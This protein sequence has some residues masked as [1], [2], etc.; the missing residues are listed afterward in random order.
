MN[1][2]RDLTIVFTVTED[3]TVDGLL[4]AFDLNDTWPDFLIGVRM[5]HEGSPGRPRRRKR[6]PC[7]GPR[8]TQTPHDTATT[9]AE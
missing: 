3:V 8:T 2:V 1:R 6:N 7:A 9:R 4:N 5:S